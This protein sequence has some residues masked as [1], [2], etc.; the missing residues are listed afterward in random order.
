MF[1]SLSKNKIGHLFIAGTIFFS[2]LIFCFLFLFSNKAKASSNI[3]D[4]WRFGENGFYGDINNTNFNDVW[5]N[6]VQWEYGQVNLYD[7]YFASQLFEYNGYVRFHQ[8]GG[9]STSLEFTPSEDGFSYSWWDKEDWQNYSSGFTVSAKT[10]RGG[11]EVNYFWSKR[12][13]GPYMYAGSDV[14]NGGSFIQVDQN[15]STSRGNW[16]HFVVNVSKDKASIYKNGV[17][18]WEFEFNNQI[19]FTSDISKI[20]FDNDYNSRY[21][22]TDLAVFNRLLTEQEIVGIYE[23]EAS[24]YDYEFTSSGGGSEENIYCSD[25]YTYIGDGMCILTDYYNPIGIFFFFNPYDCANNSTCKI[26]Y[27]YDEDNLTAYDYIS[28]YELTGFP[29]SFER[30]FIAS[31]TIIDSTGFFSD[32]TNGDS[33]FTLTGSSTFSGLKQYD[34]VGHKAGYWSASLGIDI[35]PTETIP[36]V[37]S[38]NWK[39]QDIPNLADIISATSTN[40]FYDDSAMYYAACTEEEWN[41]PPPEIFGVDVP[42]LNLTIIGCKFKL[43]FIIAGNKFTALA[44]DGIYR[45]GNI[46]KNVFPFNVYTNLNSAWKASANTQVISELA[47]LSPVDGNLTV[48]IPTTGTSSAEMVFWGKDIFTSSSTLGIDNAQKANQLFLAIKT[49]IKWALWGLFGL[50]VI[51]NAKAFI[52]KMTEGN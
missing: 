1:R 31:S 26:R 38:V 41:T 16:Y 49:I 4:I 35:P 32:K 10:V 46:L 50:W 2:V 28:V 30:T 15:F 25:G 14:G 44:T 6:Y 52:Q 3:V 24:I 17:L 8:S 11:Q 48:K 22:L 12:S 18:S 37:I 20:R 33:F 23:S 29:Y 45:A 9:M 19:S 34:V 40:P 42:A 27:K 47:F 39:S 13:Y 51:K 5:T 36:Y 7:G 21:F 43:G